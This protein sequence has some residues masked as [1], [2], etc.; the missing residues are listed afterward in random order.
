MHVEHLPTWQAARTAERA[1]IRSEEPV[2]N[3]AD[4]PGWYPARAADEGR[5]AHR[6]T[7]LPVDAAP[8]VMPVTQARTHFSDLVNRVSC[9]GRP[10]RLTRRDRVTVALISP[11]DYDLLMAFK[12]EEGR[13]LTNPA[14]GDPS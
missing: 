8:L 12:A 14:A 5:R 1:A 2:H 4:R 3:V 7:D 9:D 6:I 11:E 13:R 10:V